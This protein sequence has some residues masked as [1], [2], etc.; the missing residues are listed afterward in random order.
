[1]L[2]L[3]LKGKAADA[4]GFATLPSKWNLA[5]MVRRDMAA[6]RAAWLDE[7]KDNAELLKQR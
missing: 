3:W 7:A 2:A 1:M 4:P 6:A 5:K